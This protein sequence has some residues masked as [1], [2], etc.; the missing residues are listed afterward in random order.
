[1][2]YL[3]F[4]YDLKLLSKY[5][6]FVLHANKSAKTFLKANTVKFSAARGPNS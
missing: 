2:N 4:F 1:M 3:V 6:I 5:R